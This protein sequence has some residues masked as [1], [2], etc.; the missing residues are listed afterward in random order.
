[1]RDG[2]FQFQ[3]PGVQADAAVGI[4]AGS[5]VFQ[6]ALD[7]A[8]YLG[9]L[10]SDLVVPA[11]MQL[12]LQE[13]ITIAGSNKLVVQYR[14]LGIGHLVVIGLGGIRLLVA[15]EPVRQGAA[16]LRRL[17]GYDGPVGFPYLL[18]S[19]K[20]FVQA[21][22]GLAGLGK[23]YYAGYGSVQAMYNA[24]E[25]I[26]RLVVLLLQP[27]LDNIR[28]GSIAGLV[29]LYDLPALFVYDYYMIIFV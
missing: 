11:C 12:Y 5:A 20:E 1:M 18:M 25:N 15:G 16:L 8:A 21:G 24:Q 9:Q 27:G 28:E 14:F 7:G 23:E 3:V 17:V 22:Q 19:G 4:A 13:V 26:S 10:A 6:V 29:S 2:V